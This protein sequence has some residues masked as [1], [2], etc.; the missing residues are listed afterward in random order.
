[1]SYDKWKARLAGEK[2]IAYLRP[3]GA[4]EG[5]YRRPIV[6]GR[7]PSGRPNITGWQPVA[8]WLDDGALVG[9]IGNRDMSA[10]E[11]TSEELWSYAVQNPISYETYVTVLDGGAWPTTA[12]PG[13]VITENQDPAAPAEK[14]P[15]TVE[16]HRDAIKTI[17]DSIETM[18]IDSEE[19]AAIWLGTKNVLGSLRLAADKAGKAVYE[20]PYREYDKAFKEWN[21]MV[22][23]AKQAEDRI[24]LARKRF[25]EQRRQAALRAAA[26]AER[27]R[28]E[29]EER[30]AR[31]ADRAISRGEEPEP[32]QVEEATAPIP[33]VPAPVAPTVGRAARKLEVQVFVDQI[34]DEAAVCAFF[35]GD[36]DLTALLKTLALRAIKRGQTVPG[37][38]TREG[39]A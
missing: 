23:A 37:I 32:P 9:T 35:R 36:P 17:V 10:N 20:P 7:T 11:L 38:T 5:Y 14:A 30:N 13:R 19:S 16:E 25:E 4:D 33:Q 26:A 31:A 21:P 29:E 2:V 8:Y 18:K 22:K 6:E 12:K 39:Y 34:T 3:D 27:A 15:E 1:M 24:E 28:Q